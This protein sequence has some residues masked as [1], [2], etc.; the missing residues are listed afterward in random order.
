MAAV[1]PKEVDGNMKMNDQSDPNSKTYIQLYLGKATIEEVSLIGAPLGDL[2]D[3][4]PLRTSL[5]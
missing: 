4:A 1:V 2:V 3:E 5:F